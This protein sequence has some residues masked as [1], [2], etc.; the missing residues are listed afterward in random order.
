M[1]SK[2][3]KVIEEDLR[4][5]KQRINELMAIRTELLKIPEV[6][7][8]FEVDEEYRKLSKEAD[9][10]SNEVDQARQ[11][12]CTHPVWYYGKTTID[13][14][15]GKFY[16]SCMCMS[17]AKVESRR[18]KDF[19]I[20]RVIYNDSGKPRSIDINFYHTAKLYGKFMSLGNNEFHEEEKSK[21]FVK[22]MKRKD[23]GERLNRM[24]K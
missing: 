20:E 14:L 1:V 3:I 7:K 13:S 8:F 9:E 23:V 17:C 6:K 24:G 2:D 22:I 19:D 18:S 21:M 10:V 15:D 11:E 16:W 5:K 12:L 4:V